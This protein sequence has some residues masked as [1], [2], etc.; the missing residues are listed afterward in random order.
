MKLSKKWLLNLIFLFLM[1]IIVLACN[2]YIITHINGELHMS[3]IKYLTKSKALIPAFL[4]L[5]KFVFITLIYL[6]LTDGTKYYE[7]LN[8][9]QNDIEF[10]R[11]KNYSILIYN[12]FSQY[13]PNYLIKKFEQ[14]KDVK[15]IKHYNPKG[16]CVSLY[17]KV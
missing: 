10:M 3:I 7:I 6:E 13:I 12:E 1:F 5:L 4:L 16:N 8:V 11:F 2:M 17:I 14:K 15:V 9:K